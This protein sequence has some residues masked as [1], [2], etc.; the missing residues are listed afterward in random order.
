MR[1]RSGRVV[2]HKDQNKPQK[3]TPK[4][5]KEKVSEPEKKKK[6]TV[7]KALENYWRKR[8]GVAPTKSSSGSS[9]KAQAT[10]STKKKSDDN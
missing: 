2:Q 4:P 10:R 3:K 7:P 5:E 6:G 1:L 9:P 8:L